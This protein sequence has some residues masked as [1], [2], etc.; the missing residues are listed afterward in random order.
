MDS[1]R[2]FTIDFDEWSSLARQDPKGFEARRRATLD[3][4]IKAQPAGRRQRLR[5][6]QWRVDRIR[7]SSS[8]PLL[9]CQ[10]LSQLMWDAFVGPTGLMQILARPYPPARD[11]QQ[12][13]HSAKILPF[14][15]PIR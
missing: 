2:C 7:Q 11:T 13:L 6:L 14:R 1:E 4:F 9:A 12:A 3:S 10:R 5:C 8:T 15:R